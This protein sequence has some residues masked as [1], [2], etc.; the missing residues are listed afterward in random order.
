MVREQDQ[1]H[2]WLSQS[3]DQLW[4]QGFGCGGFGSPAVGGGAGADLV[5]V[6]GAR[7]EEHFFDLKRWLL[8][9]Y[10]AGAAG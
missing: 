6:H 3:H 2:Q 7:P 4:P 5:G 9:H 1:D 10:S 8:Q